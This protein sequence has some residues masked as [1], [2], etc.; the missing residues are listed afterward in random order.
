VLV[1]IYS[2][3]HPQKLKLNLWLHLKLVCPI[4]LYKCFK[5]HS[6]QL[7]L[8]IICI[9]SQI[10][11][12]ERVYS[13]HNDYYIMKSTNSMKHSPL[14]TTSS[15]ASQEISHIR[16]NPQVDYH[17]QRS[18]QLSTCPKLSQVNYVR[19]LSDA[20]LNIQFNITI[21]WKPTSSK[22][23][24]TFRFPCQNSVFISLLSCVRCMLGPPHPP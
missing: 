2:R 13:L 18:Q 15:W 11:V 14:R 12:T 22:R 9:E 5:K 17:S 21:S 24:I 19:V 20:V 23:S 4:F 10:N 7:I 8:V 6:N 1:H 16:W 3:S